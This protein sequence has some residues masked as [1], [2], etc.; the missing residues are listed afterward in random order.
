MPL[1]K[2]GSKAAVSENI[3]R[4][5]NAGKPQKQAIAI[6]LNVARKYAG[7]GRLDYVDRESRFNDE[8]TEDEKTRR[9]K[10]MEDEHNLNLLMMDILK[11]D[12]PTNADKAMETSPYA[13]P[14]PFSQ[15]PIDTPHPQGP[16]GGPQRLISKAEGGEI[17]T[18]NDR[19]GNMPEE[20]SK[21]ERLLSGIRRAQEVTGVTPSEEAA[22]IPAGQAAMG[23]IPQALMAMGPGRGSFISPMQKLGAGAGAYL[24]FAPG[25]AQA[26]GISTEPTTAEQADI[27]KLSALMNERRKKYEQAVRRDPT[28][29]I[30]Q[31][32][33]L[34]IDALNAE[35]EK[36]QG[37]GSPLG[38]RRA[39]ALKLQSER[40]SQESAAE[41]ALKGRQTEAQLPYAVKYPER[42][43][44]LQ[45]NMP[46]F[47]GATGAAL[48]LLGRGKVLKPLAAAAGAGAAEGAMTAAWPTLQDTEFLPPGQTW[49]EAADRL[50]NTDPDFMKRVGAAAATHGAI[51][52][53]SSLVG[54]KAR[55]LMGQL[56]ETLSKVFS[57]EAGT[58]AKKAAK[59]KIA[60][61]EVHLP[62]GSVVK[63]YDY[64]NRIA[65]G[66]NV[67]GRFKWISP[68]DIEARKAVTPPPQIQPESQT[69]HMLQQADG[70]P[71]PAYADGGAPPWYARDAMRS[72]FRSGM[73]NSRVPGRTDKL[74]ISVKANSYVIPADVVSALGE[75]NSMAGE[76]V[77]NA[78]FKGGPYG[79]KP[80]TGHNRA[81]FADG[82]STQNTP[83]IAAGGEYVVPPEAV[84]HHGKGDFERGHKVLDMFVKNTRRNNIKTLQK[85][86][87]PK[88]D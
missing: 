76:H 54:S 20:P 59:P 88:K 85:L 67:G 82:G 47:S 75:G 18:F 22:Q 69:M 62:D 31:S 24:Q 40:S 56:G 17:D 57:K 77:L 37:P 34:A 29:N 43:A 11:P 46:S 73:L 7:G 41:M 4:E 1:V 55:D 74:P 28:G 23:A 48:G 32:H 38:L 13:L 45:E 51:A 30:A 44:W 70:G 68:N 72:T 21:Y 36:L 42:Q 25:E 53:G 71:I 12:M 6:A 8:P 15:V 79:I 65:Y 83:I 50:Y 5:R 33:K 52:G 26:Q 84:A 64:G 66:E 3:R 16:F 19:F 58:V 61:I 63:K 35:M 78:M 39:A 80:L 60:P 49:K 10:R 2:S 86:P 9:Y 81:K 87:G 27:A 14:F